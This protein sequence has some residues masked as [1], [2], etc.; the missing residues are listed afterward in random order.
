MTDKSEL[1]QVTDVRRKIADHAEFPVAYW[2]LYGFALVLLAGV[3]IWMSWLDAVG[4]PFLPWAI[5]A[6]GIASAAYAVI[7]RSRS[8][9]HLPQW[10]GA[11]PSARPIWLIS[12][13]ISLIG[14][15]GI[16]LL[17]NVG[18]PVIALLALAV[19]A[20]AVFITQF[21]TRSAMRR[22]LESGRVQP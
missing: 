18:Q 19:V 2:V 15:L 5:A 16:Y 10:I 4:N 1:D 11:Y 9:V 14:L 3:P 20:P 6:V 12:L 17:V 13:A 7:R 8:G 22:D 21:K